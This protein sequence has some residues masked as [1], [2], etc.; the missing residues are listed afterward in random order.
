MWEYGCWKTAGGAV[1]K[2]ESKLCAVEREVYEEV[3]V[4]LDSAFTPV[5]L[6]GWHVAGARDRHVNDN[7]STFA[8]R[9]TSEAIAVDGSEIVH[10]RWFDIKDL[11]AAEH[12]ALSSSGSGGVDNNQKE[13]ALSAPPAVRRGHAV[14]V[15]L[16]SL[17]VEDSR[18]GLVSTATLRW[19]HT[20]S[21]GKGWMCDSKERTDIGTGHAQIN[22][23]G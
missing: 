17:G 11:L 5:Y 23:S 12:C 16:S 14:A 22:F 15:D 18:K 10:A 20:Y 4:K 13:A 2:G 3:G 7:F 1:D 9:A 21:D 6:G 8:V 19:L